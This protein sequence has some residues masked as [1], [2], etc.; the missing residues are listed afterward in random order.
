MADTTIQLIIATFADEAAAET[1]Y[2]GLVKAGKDKQVVLEN[3]A[4][5]KHAVDGKIDIREEHEFTGKKGAAAGAVIGGVLGIIG[6]PLGIAM[7][8]AVGA[9]LGG[10][11]GK[12]IDT[13]ISNERLRYLGEAIAG[14][15]AAIMALAAPESV[16]A[17]QATLTSGGATIATEELQAQI[18]QEIAAAQKSGADGMQAVLAEGLANQGKGTAVQSAGEAPSNW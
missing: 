4:L 12:T 2:Q 3:A 6:G 10:L 5:V 15:S 11:A 8:A 17:V 16:A 14:G 7:G 1:A 13:G 9:G 18:L